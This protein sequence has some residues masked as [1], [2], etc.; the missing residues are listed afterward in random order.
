MGTADSTDDYPPGAAWSA[1]RTA[2]SPALAV[3]LGGLVSAAPGKSQLGQARPGTGSA[4][5]L[6]AAS[7]S[8]QDLPRAVARR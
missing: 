6:C 2:C 3:P 5:K 7:Q 4:D 8:G 1:A